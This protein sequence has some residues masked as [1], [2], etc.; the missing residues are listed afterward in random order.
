LVSHRLDGWGHPY[1]SDV[2]ETVSLIAA[3]LTG[4]A[5]RHGSAP[6]RD[7]HMRLAVTTSVIRLE[8]TDTRTEKQ[9]TAVRAADLDAEGGRGLFLVSRL[10]TRWAVM[11]RPSGP[12]KTV[13]AELH[14]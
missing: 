13:W 11:P 10:A 2:N 5:V 7:F 14:V 3:E 1:A 12:G 9:P 8:V 4:N 6:G